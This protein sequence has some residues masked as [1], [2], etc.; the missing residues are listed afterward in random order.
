MTADNHEK[1]KKTMLRIVSQKPAS[2]GSKY[3]NENSG[4][5]LVL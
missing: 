2:V 3:E 1:K 5:I 4:Q